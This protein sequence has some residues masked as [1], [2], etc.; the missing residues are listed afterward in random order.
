M[1]CDSRR[2][3]SMSGRTTV[4]SGQSR[5]A[6]PIGIAERTPEAPRDIAAGQHHAAH[7][8]ADDHRPVGELR[9]VAL[10]DAGIERIAIDMRDGQPGELGMGDEAGRAAGGTGCDGV[11]RGRVEPAAIP[12]QHGRHLGLRPGARAEINYAGHDTGLVRM[13]AILTRP[14]LR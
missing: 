6:W 13:D 2:Y 7:A 4:A 10:L 8:A 1:R 5:R 11:R 14:G 3:F 9:P 12:A